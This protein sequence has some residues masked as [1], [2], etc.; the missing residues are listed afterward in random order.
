[1]CLSDKK[2]DFPLIR[3]RRI[4]EG[5]LGISCLVRMSG[6]EVVE[7]FGLSSNNREHKFAGL[8][9]DGPTSSETTFC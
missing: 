9:L 4:S 1:M 2:L 8:Y 3:T 6:Q 5:A 7:T